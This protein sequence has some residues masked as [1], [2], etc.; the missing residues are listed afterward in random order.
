M[1]KSKTLLEHKIGER[2]YEFH[3]DPN[4]PLGE[5]YDAISV[6]RNFIIG[7]INEL[8][9]KKCEEPCKSCEG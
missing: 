7:K 1:I 5:I 8:E 4:S 6:M 3:C 2:I 9:E